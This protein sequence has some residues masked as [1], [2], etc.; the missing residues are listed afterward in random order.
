MKKKEK[1]KFSRRSFLKL[2]GA[3]TALLATGI[4]PR[5]ALAGTVNLEDGWRDFSYKTG[6]ERQA[7]P[8]ACWQCVTRDAAIG[9]VEDGKLVKLEGNPDSIRG[10]GK[11]C[12]RGQAGVN[13]VYDPDRI[14]YPMKRVGARGSGQWARITWEEALTELVSKLKPLRD[15]GT[16]EKFMFHYGRMK[17]SSSKLIKSLFLH[18]YGTKTIGNHTS[19]C[20]SAKWTAQELTWGGHYDNWDFDNT[21]FVLNFGSNVLECHTNHIPM[22]QRLI[23]AK[24][25]RG[26]RVV[27]FDVRQSNTA[28]KSDEWFAIKP[29]TDGAVM[30]AM[31]NVIMNEGLNDPGFLSF[32]KAT[33]NHDATESEKINSLLT[34]LAPYT[35]QWAEG[36]SGVPAADIVRLARE[37]ANTKPACLIT[38]RGAVMHYNGVE[39]ER[40]AQMLAAITGNIDNPGGRCKAVGA[41]WSYPHGP[42]PPVEKGLSIINGFP[43]QAAYPTHHISHQVLKMIKDGS[44][45]VPEVYMWY[46]YTPVYANGE[47]DENI[48]V[49][50]DIIPYNVAVTPFYDESAAYAD[51]ILPDATYLERWDWE[52]MV[53]PT[54]VA[55]YYI[56]QPVIQPLGEAWNFAD[57][58]IE[59]ADRMGFPLGVT[60]MEDFVRQSADLTLGPNAFDYLKTNGVWHDPNAQPR[61]YSYQETATVPLGAIY[62]DA[63]GVWWMGQPG[64]DY[65]TTSSAYKKYIGQQIGSGVYVGFK[66][67]AVNKSGYLELYSA[68]LELKGF[69]PMPSYLPIPE[70]QTMAPDQLILT[71][72]KQQVQTHSRTQNCKWLTEMFH[73]NPAWINPATAANFGIVDGDTVELTSFVTSMTTPVRVTSDIVPGVIAIS[74]HLGHWQYGRYASGVKAPIEGGAHDND[75]DLQYKWWDSYGELTR[76]EI[77]RLQRDHQDLL[78]KWWDTYGVHA[79]WVMPNSPDPIGGA[80]RWMDTVVSVRKIQIKR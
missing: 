56:R 44:F 38:Y 30:L 77:D 41:G 10:Q 27:T 31:C 51:L 46:C 26:V 69:N 73:H 80:Q 55:E 65:T 49:L 62:D 68:L 59:L 23:S 66:P 75:P 29:G 7:V 25:D 1:S 50:R 58:C 72:Y 2:G 42:E 21:Q 40:I 22:S 43:G 39:N 47:I 6:L 34:H 78:H 5:S 4:W 54:Q 61:Y 15:A 45:G 76:E 13:Q 18:A 16:P 74:H 12:A 24:V 36:V 79:N 71:I 70:H 67:D 32:V 20:E 17:A 3:S 14:L 48:E 33:P 28:A 35:P 9:F 37:F 64:E 19:I 53:S 63:T 52:D 11:L 8:T 60:S 57:V